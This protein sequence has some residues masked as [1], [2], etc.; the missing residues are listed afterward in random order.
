MNILPPRTKKGATFDARD[1]VCE[2]VK[3][4]ASHYN[5]QTDLNQIDIQSECDIIANEA[6][7][8]WR[9]PIGAYRHYFW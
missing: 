1:E 4:L 3:R 5:N 6:T 9:R 8:R 7:K 2:Y